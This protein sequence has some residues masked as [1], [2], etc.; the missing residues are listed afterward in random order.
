MSATGVVRVR[1]AEGPEVEPEPVTGMEG[2]VP[3]EWDSLER[4]AIEDALEQEERA[5]KH[6][7]KAKDSKKSW[8][9]EKARKEAQA[10]VQEELA[11]KR[12]KN[13]AGW[14]TR[15]ASSMQSLDQLEEV[16][17]VSPLRKEDKSELRKEHMDALLHLC[18]PK[19]RAVIEKGRDV[20]ERLKIN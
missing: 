15:V 17:S 5:R 2:I 14:K 13:I 3:L 19:N 8:K 7:T 9:K 11:K 20:R 6:S 4:M 12:E 18:V 1:V 16:L 10:K